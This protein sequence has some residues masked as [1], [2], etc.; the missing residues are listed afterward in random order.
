M[1]ALRDASLLEAVNFKDDNAD[2]ERNLNSR[3]AY[4]SKSDKS[5]STESK[6]KKRRMKPQHQEG[7]ED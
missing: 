6:G 7:I 5:D 1:K 2:N 3:V 4:P